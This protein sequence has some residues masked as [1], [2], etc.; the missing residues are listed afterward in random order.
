MK[1]I[2]LYV[3]VLFFSTDIFSQVNSLTKLDNLQPPVKKILTEFFSECVRERFFY[4]D[5]GIVEVISYEDSLSKENY[6]LS[7]V[8]DDRFLENPPKSYYINENGDFFLFYKGDQFGNKIKEI[9]SNK[10]IDD[11]QKLIGDRVYIR[12]VKMERFVELNDINGNLK[13]IC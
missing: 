6:L 1:K 2:I 11:L 13:K 4:E 9:I 8:I 10:S 7:A 3:C 5:K 12:P